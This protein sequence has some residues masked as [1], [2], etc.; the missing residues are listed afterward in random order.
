[1]RPAPEMLAALTFIEH[2]KMWLQHREFVIR[3]DNQAFSWLKTYST[4]SEHVTRWIN[5]LGTF[6]MVI[7]HRTRNHHTNA[8]GLSKKTEYYQRVEARPMGDKAVGFQFLSQEAYDALP[9]TDNLKAPVAVCEITTT[10]DSESQTT[11][12]HDDALAHTTPSEEEVTHVN[13]TENDT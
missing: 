12:P 9:D 11:E 8:D 7:Q 6:N 5:S 10:R 1:M 3:C 4:K 2:N 13:T